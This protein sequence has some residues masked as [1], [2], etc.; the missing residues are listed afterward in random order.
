M[1]QSP[2]Q[3][4]H[5]RAVEQHDGHFT[6]GQEQP[7]Q[8]DADKR[9]VAYAADIA[10]KR[11]AGRVLLPKE[12]KSDGKCPQTEAQRCQHRGDADGQK[13][14]GVHGGKGGKQHG[15]ET[16][17]QQHGGQ[18]VCRTLRHQPDLQDQIADGND[19]DKEQ[20]TVD[21][22]RMPS[23]SKRTRTRSSTISRLPLSG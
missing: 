12:E 18:D 20:K 2:N 19:N 17:V 23:Y 16:D 15:R 5:D 22:H 7:Q 14:R 9:C 8:R 6:G 10:Q 13:L 3:N 21:L 1:V 11:A 4:I